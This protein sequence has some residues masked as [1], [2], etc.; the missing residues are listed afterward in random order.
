MNAAQA[1]QHP[2]CHGQHGTHRRRLGTHQPDIDQRRHPARDQGKTIANQMGGK[3]KL[4]RPQH[5]PE[6]N[7][8]HRHMKP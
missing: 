6:Q 4:Q 3:K 1:Q 7:G 5:S 8:D 2:Q